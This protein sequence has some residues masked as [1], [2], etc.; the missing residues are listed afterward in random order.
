MLILQLIVAKKNLNRNYSYLELP[1]MVQLLKCYVVFRVLYL[2]RMVI[3]FIQVY[4]LS[5]FLILVDISFQQL[6]LRYAL[7]HNF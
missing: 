1:Q 4:F 3:D 7:K 5:C 6:P 2:K